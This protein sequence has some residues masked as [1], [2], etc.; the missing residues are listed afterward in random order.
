MK[1]KMC[2]ALMLSSL[3]AGPVMAEEVRLHGSTTTVEEVVKPVL[4]AVEKATGYTI[5]VIPKS[6][7]NGLIDLVEGRCDASITSASI[8]VTAK[9]AQAEG[10]PVKAE[11]LQ[12]TVVKEDVTA[13]IVNPSNPVT[14][15]SRE[16]LKDIYTGKAK[17]WKDVGGPDMPLL[18]LT[19]GTGGGTRNLVQKEVLQGEDFGI[20]VRPA[21]STNHVFNVVSEFPNAFGGL[22]SALVD[23]LGDE[24]GDRSKVKIV[25]TVKVALPLGFITLGTPTGKVKNVIDAVIAETKN[26]RKG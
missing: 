5:S 11:D 21:I 16:Q 12:L 6:S 19:A 13:F 8:E 14:A 9:A 22:S 18:V 7:A 2:L 1:G 10:K 20:E 25:Q 15:L 24:L 4:S 26:R 3:M 17:N 23:R